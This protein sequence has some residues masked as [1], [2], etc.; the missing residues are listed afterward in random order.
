MR[1]DVIVELDQL[2]DFIEEDIREDFEKEVG[3]Q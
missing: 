2:L 3:D 1:C